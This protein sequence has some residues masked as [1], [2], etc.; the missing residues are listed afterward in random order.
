MIPARTSVRHFGE[1]KLLVF[2]DQIVH[3]KFKHLEDYL[4]EGDLIV[5]NRSATLPSCFEGRI[6]RTSETL[7][8][9]LAAFQGPDENHLENWLAFSFGI[10]SWRVPTEERKAPPEVRAGDKI[11][12][13]DDFFAEV[14]ACQKQRLLQLHFHFSHVNSFYAHGKPIQ[15]SYLTEELEVWDQQTIFSGPP[16]SVEPPSAAF[17]LTWDQILK[18]KAKGVKVAYLLHSAGISSTGSHELDQLLPLPEWYDV[19][20]E[21]VHKVMEAKRGNKKIIAVGTTV[22]RALESAWSFHPLHSG[23]G[24]TD[25]KITEDYIVQTATGIITGMHEIGASHMQILNSF[26]SHEMID[27]A[28]RQAEAR[29]YLGHE[30]GDLSLLVCRPRF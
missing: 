7:E 23:S 2:S 12:F 21:T 16:I 24:L 3:S 10:G 30:Y 17:Q 18:L 26:C 9:R 29:N 25:L 28:Y 6:E 13:A 8:I 20:E 14:V 15:Y 19:P 4:G 5:V 27:E 11:I 1:S 22:L